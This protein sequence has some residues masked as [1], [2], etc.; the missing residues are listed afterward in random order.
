MSKRGLLRSRRN[1]RLGI[2]DQSAMPSHL[3]RGR[4]AL[5]ALLADARC[6]A[7]VVADPAD[8]PREEILDVP[9]G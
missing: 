1:A 4:P 7:R 9:A 2:R 5:V 6:R 8:Q 3:T